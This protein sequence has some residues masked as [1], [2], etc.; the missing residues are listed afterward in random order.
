[1]LR[2][3]ISFQRGIVG[4]AA[5]LQAVKVGSLKE[6]L[7]LGPSQSWVAKG[8]SGCNF[9]FKSSTLT[10]CNFAVS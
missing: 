4:L 5:K 1:M 3:L 6:I 2:R 9:F 8:R 7:L 10:A